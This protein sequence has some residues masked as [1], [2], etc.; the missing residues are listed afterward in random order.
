MQLTEKHKEYWH[1]NLVITAILL[2]DLVRRHLRR[3][4][5]R[6]RAE[7]HHVPRLPA[8]L[9]HVGAGLADHLRGD[10]LVSTRCYM[11]KLDIEYGVD[12]GEDE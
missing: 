10:H 8:G 3:S 9:L 4:L 2:V 12:E 6:A 7:R 1:K 11:N 5:V